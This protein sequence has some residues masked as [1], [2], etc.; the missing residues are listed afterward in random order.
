VTFSTAYIF[1]NSK[2]IRYVVTQ[3][4]ISGKLYLDKQLVSKC[5]FSY[6]ISVV[7][8]K[9]ICGTVGTDF[10]LQT[11]CLFYH[12]LSYLLDYWLLTCRHE[13]WSRMEMMEMAAL[14]TRTLICPKLQSNHHHQNNNS[15]FTGWPSQQCQTLKAK[16]G[17]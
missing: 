9:I 5:T 8:L 14:Q 6:H 4:T 16:T 12:L 2:A 15:G 10:F 17:R 3:V 13:A 11:R 7:F 1:T